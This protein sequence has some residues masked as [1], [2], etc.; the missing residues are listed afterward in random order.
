[1]AKA[2]KR[3]ATHKKNSKRGKASSKSARKKAAPR[4]MAAKSKPAQ[5]IAA[6]LGHAVNVVVET[7]KETAEMRH[8]M[9]ADQPEE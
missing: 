6:K 9:H 7:I 1:M 5:G 4:R 8:K 3:V 2:K